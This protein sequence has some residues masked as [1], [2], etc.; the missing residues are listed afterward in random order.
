MSLQFVVDGAVAGAVT[1]LGAVG[2]TLTYSILRFANFAHGEFIAAGAYATL[3][4]GGAIGVGLGA[5]SPPLGPFSFSAVTLVAA[6][7][8][9]GVTGALA[10][11]LDAVLFRRLRDRG[12][13]VVAIMASF[14]ASMALR[15]LFEAVFT[16]RPAY[17]TRML[18][19]A[20][21]IGFGLKATPNQLALF[22]LALLLMV[23]LHGLMTRTATGRAMRAVSENPGLARVAGLDV[24]RTIR[25]TWLLG[26]ALA[27][28]AGTVVGLLVQ[29]RPGM[30]F[31]LLLPL[32]AAAILGGIGS[33]PGAVLGG[34]TVGFAEAAA[35]AFAG[36]QWRGAVAFAVLIGVLLLRPTGLFG[37]PA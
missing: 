1:G 4:I 36:A 19:I 16:S 35:V 2:V 3:A 20:R 37:R 7:L 32:F 8:A 22:G 18:Q 5:A 12:E 14:G 17:F 25:L 24:G 21:P 30:G 33:V 28:A 10:L 9:M 26:G 29:I 13:A 31:D 11:A 15:S 27:G 6:V 23:L 34:F